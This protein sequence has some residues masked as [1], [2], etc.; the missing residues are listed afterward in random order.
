MFHPDISNYFRDIGPLQI[1]LHYLI[2]NLATLHFMKV[3]SVRV[4]CYRDTT[5]INTAAFVI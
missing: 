5:V 4:S 2:G 1:N 3:L